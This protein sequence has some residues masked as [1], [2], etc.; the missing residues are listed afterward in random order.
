[1][2]TRNDEEKFLHRKIAA[3][4][5]FRSFTFDDIL[6]YIGPGN[7]MISLEMTEKEAVKQNNDEDIQEITKTMPSLLSIAQK[8]RMFIRSIEEKVPI[9]Q[10]KRINYNAIAKLSRDSNDWYSRTLVSVKPK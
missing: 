3:Y 4:P 6:K 1:M 9:D 5:G 8:P 7:S 10:A 2:S